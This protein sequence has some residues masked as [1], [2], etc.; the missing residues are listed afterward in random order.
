MSG[1]R[2]DAGL[3][4]QQESLFPMTARPNIQPVVDFT[5]NTT[6]NLPSIGGNQSSA[7]NM[8]LPD[9]DN[10]QFT[11]DVNLNNQ[12]GWLDSFKKWN[13]PSEGGLLTTLDKNG[14]AVPTNLGSAF[15]IGKDLFGAWGAMQNRKLAKKQF[16]FT[17]DS[18]NKQYDAQKRLTNASLR[19]RQ[20][21][22]EAEGTARQS[23]DEYMKQNGVQ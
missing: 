14:N 8:Q 12:G 1:F 7:F 11:G 17:V 6:M 20:M 18:F 15:N 23:T 19:D 10:Y 5:R 21:R 22:R 16:N 2:F 9:M 4:Q 13:Q 3:T